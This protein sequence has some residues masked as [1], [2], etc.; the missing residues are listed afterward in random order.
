MTLFLST[1]VNRVDKKC[2]V[3]VPSQFRSTIAN[4]SFAG[5]V[6]YKS[7][8][9]D[10]IEGCAMSRIEK[11]SASIDALDPL[12]EERDAFA[13]A[14]LG[15]STQ[16]QFDTDGRVVL[17]KELIEE[18]G[19]EEN[20]LFVGKGQTFEIWE[21]GKF[22]VYAQTAKRIALEKRSILRSNN[23]Q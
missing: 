19:I 9:N 14:I 4:E 12:S 20:A 17:P 5:I 18:I 6:I 1:Y 16:L 8:I 7:V 3:S 10:C 21:P 2:R 11:I 22:Q 13:T 15:S 23:N